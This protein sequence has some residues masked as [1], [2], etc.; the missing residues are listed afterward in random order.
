MSPPV[1]SPE[2]DIQPGSDPNLIDPTS[3]GVVPVAILGSASFDVADIDVTTLALGPIGAGSVFDLT[4]WLI[5]L[6]SSRDINHDGYGDLT[7]VY[8]IRETGIAFGDTDTCIT[9]D[10]EDGTPFESCDAIQTV[11]ACGIGFELALLLLPLLW[12]HRRRRHT[13]RAPSRQLWGPSEASQRHRSPA[14]LLTPGA[15]TARS[16]GRMLQTAGRDDTECC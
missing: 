5:R 3:R 8:R 12:V 6:L 16:A 14:C 4:H 7:S 1:L 15:L 11:A 2:I 13:A 10:L 9:G